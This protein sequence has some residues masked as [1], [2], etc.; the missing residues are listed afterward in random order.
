MANMM[1]GI[2]LQGSADSGYGISL[3][4]FHCPTSEYGARMTDLQKQVSESR[5][6][7]IVSFE[8]NGYVTAIVLRKE[9]GLPTPQKSKIATFRRE[10]H[11]FFQDLPDFVRKTKAQ[12]VD[13]MTITGSLGS[14]SLTVLYRPVEEPGG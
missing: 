9:P 10:P 14:I 11:K 3:A 8:D 12:F 13:R 5:I 6:T 1:A 2:M 4:G 7:D